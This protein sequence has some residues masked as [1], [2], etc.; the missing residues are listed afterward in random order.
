MGTLLDLVMDA[1]FGLLPLPFGRARRRPAVDPG[2]TPDGRVKEIYL[3]PT[4]VHARNAGRF[5]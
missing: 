1:V 3:D 5:R 2:N 4:D